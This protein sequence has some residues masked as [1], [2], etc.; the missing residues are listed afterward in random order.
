IANLVVH[1]DLNC[2]SV[3]QFAVD[4]LKVRHVIVCGHYGCSGVQAALARERL[5]L[6]DNWLRHVQD[7]RLKHE[8]ALARAPNPAERLCELNVIEQVANVCHTSIA[9]DAWDR[10]QSLAVH[11]WVYGINDGLLKDLDVTVN[12][13]A[14]A[15]EVYRA[16]LR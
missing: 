16:A 8:E 7:V 11:G 13:F 9:R 12:G 2:L 14:E 6:S 10:G 15:G 1:T 4:I 5:G 3:M